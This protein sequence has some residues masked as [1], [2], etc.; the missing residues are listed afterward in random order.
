[1]GKLGEKCSCYDTK[2]VIVDY[3]CYTHTPLTKTVGVCNGTKERDEC[4]CNGIERFCDFYKYKRE[5]AVTSQNEQSTNKCR[6][7]DPVRNTS[8]MA[9]CSE[10]LEDG[11]YRNMDMTAYYCPNCGRK[12]R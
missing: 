8:I 6:Y 7:C 1:M 4:T 11:S 12:I 10:L 2:E 3:N 5:R 9:V